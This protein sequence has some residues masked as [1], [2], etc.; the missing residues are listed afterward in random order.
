MTEQ[1]INNYAENFKKEFSGDASYLSGVND[2]TY[3]ILRR[4]F[5]DIHKQRFLNLINS[6][7]H[8]STKRSQS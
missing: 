3:L 1:E 8:G 5:L 2:A 7:F 6:L 4:L